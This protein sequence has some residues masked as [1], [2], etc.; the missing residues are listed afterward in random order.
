MQHFI[1]GDNVGL[2]TTRQFGSYKHFICFIADKIIEISSQPFAPYTLFPLYLY[3]D[4]FGEL[5]KTPNINNSILNQIQD[6]IQL[7]ETISPEQI[8]DYVYGRLHSPLYRDRYK[9]FLKIDFPRIPYPKNADEFW[10][11]VNAGNRLRKLHLM[12]VTTPS[13][14]ERAGVRGVGMLLA[15]SDSA[16]FNISGSNVVEKLTFINTPSALLNSN[17]LPLTP[18]EMGNI[19]EPTTIYGKVYINDTQYFDNIPIDVW[20]FY[21]GGYQPAQKW[22][23]DRK[24][25]ALTYDDITHY[26]KIINV[27]QSTIEEMGI[28]DKTH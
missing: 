10:H 11:F 5:V 6:K 8:F 9:E 28:I 18:S 26:Q 22:L 4:N 16:N 21:I 17:N 12:E 2:V 15:T 25:R 23:K 19:N 7:Q 27:L 14:E 24:G 20:N 1:K 3:Q 13:H